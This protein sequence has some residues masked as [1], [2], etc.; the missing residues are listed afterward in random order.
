MLNL[1]DI[2]KSYDMLLFNN[3]SFTLGDNEKV[4]LVGLNGCGKTTLFRI[5][6]G[7]EEPDEGMISVPGE[8]VA[9][10]PQVLTFP[11]E[12]L[13]GEFLEE[14][15]EDPASEMF[16]VNIVLNMLGLDD[17]DEYAEIDHLSDG[18]QMKL[19]MAG[20]LMGKMREKH[21]SLGNQSSNSTSNTP[22]LLLD[23]PT[24]HL[25]IE[26]ILW[27][28]EFISD[29]QGIAIIISHDRAFLNNVTDKIFEID[30][31][32]L[33]TYEGNYD[34]FIEQK[35]ARIEIRRKKHTRQ[36]KKRQQ[37]E[38]LIKNSMK[39]GDGKKRGRAVESAKKR[40]HRE[41]E[42][43]KVDLYQKRQIKEFSIAGSVHKTKKMLEV[44]NLRFGY[45]ADRPI[46]HDSDLI[47]LGGEK[48]W[49]F[50]PNGSGKTTFIKLL[51]EQ[52]TPQEGKVV[53]GNNVT[54]A[55]FSQN[56]AHLPMDETV[57]DFFIKETGVNYEKSF[58]ALNKF[59][60]DKTQRDAKISR[61]SPGQRARLSFAIFAQQNYDF[62]ILDE[63]TNHLDIETKELIEQALAD[64][65][66]NI[67]LISHDRYFV[68][69][70]NP[71]RAVHIKDGV[72]VE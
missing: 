9:T 36:E 34:D 37:L 42:K 62:L 66:G 22:I 48:V 65:A 44:S 41:V 47:I 7:E 46:I 59:L 56:Q 11:T 57:A 35:A 5:I 13:V 19:Y 24:N 27:L 14:L 69:H 40:L 31:H 32:T 29:Y 15:V 10:L 67:L 28:E 55:Y 61:L 39:I 54:Y 25:D 70:I 3:V 21:G 18:Q 16:R 58:G 33:K 53:C 26:G 23:E 2:S 1:Q 20:L 71:D 43:N 45:E 12:M 30:E 64:F 60:F 4:G 72:L 49:L 50:G 63:P 52:L 68:E 51:I 17:V 8:T 6:S 38:T